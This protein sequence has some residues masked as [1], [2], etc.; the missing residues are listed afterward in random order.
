MIAPRR[1]SPALLFLSLVAASLTV[2]ACANRPKPPPPEDPASQPVATPPADAGQAVAEGPAP[3]ESCAAYVQRTSPGVSCTV[4]PDDISRCDCAL[5]NQVAT[6][7]PPPAEPPPAEPQPPAAPG[8]AKLNFTN[9]P[10]GTTGR[11]LSDVC[12]VKNDF[13]VANG[14]PPIKLSSNPQ[15]V[16]FEFKSPAHSPKT[17]V[18]QLVPGDN[19]IDFDLGGGGT[20]SGD[21]NYATLKFSGGPSG[22]TVECISGACP[23]KQKRAVTDPYPNISMSSSE[24][25]ILLRFQAPGYRAEMARFVLQ[26]GPNLIPID[27]EEIRRDAGP[28]VPQRGRPKPN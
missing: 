15:T 16:R 14:Y 17:F 26:R 13:V 6:N 2:T 3:G 21:G 7:D 4:N 23:D 24:A 28:V 20:P 9:G 8:D 25:T 12:P 10:T 19:T 22:T 27:L 5:T 11:C 18:Y 1:T